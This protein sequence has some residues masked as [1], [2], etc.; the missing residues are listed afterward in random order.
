MKEKIKYIHFLVF[1]DFIQVDY[2][3]IYIFKIIITKIYYSQQTFVI[4]R[5]SCPFVDVVV[6]FLYCDAAESVIVSNI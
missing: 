1:C 4:S 6:I 3:Y 5:S 2:I